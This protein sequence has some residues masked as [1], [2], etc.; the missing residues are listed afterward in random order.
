MNEADHFGGT[1]LPLVARHFLLLQPV[2]DVLAH[3]LPRKQRKILKDDA[4]LG[5]G[6]MDAAVA[7]RD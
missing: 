4:A 5:R 2:E 6:T 3:R 1:P 7:G